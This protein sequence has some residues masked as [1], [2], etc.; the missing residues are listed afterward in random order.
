MTNG[1]LNAVMEFNNTRLLRAM[2]L[3][4]NQRASLEVTYEYINP[5]A[6]VEESADSTTVNSR[7]FWRYFNKLN[8]RVAC[9]V[10]DYTYTLVKEGERY[11]VARFRSQMLDNRCRN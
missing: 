2:R 1:A 3:S 10:R 4:P 11:R 6:L 5:P 9:E 8:G 7:E